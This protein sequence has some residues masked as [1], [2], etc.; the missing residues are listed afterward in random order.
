MANEITTPRPRP[1]ASDAERT[2]GIAGRS[3][4]HY[5]GLLA[6]AQRD[7]DAA[8]ILYARAMRAMVSYDDPEP[9]DQ[10]VIREI[11]DA[12]EEQSHG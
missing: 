10:D 6:A 11:L 12:V 1:T 8:S 2:A 7:F 5:A 9:R 3:M 4:A